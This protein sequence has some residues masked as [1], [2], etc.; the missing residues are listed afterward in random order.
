MTCRIE[1]QMTRAEYD[2]DPG[3]RHS[4]IVHGI[5]S[6]ARL[7]HA[8]DH[9]STSTPAM[10]FGS[11]VHQRVL[12]GA[13]YAP[14]PQGLAR[15]QRKAWSDAQAAEPDRELVTAEEWHAAG[16]IGRAVAQAEPALDPTSGN[17]TE[18][19][20]FWT[21]HGLPCKALLDCYDHGNDRIVDLKVTRD[22]RPDSFVR[23]AVRFGYFTQ[24]AWYAEAMRAQ[25]QDVAGGFRFV[26]V[27]PERPY[28][29]V[30]YDVEPGSMELARGQLQRVL[31]RVVECEAT[32]RWPDRFED[33]V[34]DLVMPDWARLEASSLDDRFDD[35]TRELGL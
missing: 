8:A 10:R 30:V 17:L 23:S 22:P 34:V 27:A 7:R 15:T 16:E 29:P 21:W 2:A 6:M 26:A 18:L 24:A 19:A 32:G 12:G 13:E 11:L 25:G 20:V 3:W 5:E 1:T 4:V 14:A 31:L 9:P 28:L 35:L 33:A